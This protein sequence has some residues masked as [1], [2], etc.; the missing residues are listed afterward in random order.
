MPEIVDLILKVGDAGRDVRG[1]TRGPSGS[2]AR[3]GLELPDGK[4]MMPGV[5]EDAPHAVA[6][7]HVV[8]LS[9]PTAKVF[10]CGR[11]ARRSSCVVSLSTSAA[12]DAKG[13]L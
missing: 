1:G 6:H 7:P 11:Y 2:S 12:D 13:L 10:D 3:G 8:T 4:I 5:I 9:N